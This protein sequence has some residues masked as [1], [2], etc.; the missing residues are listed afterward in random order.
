MT[1]SNPVQR[2]RIRAAAILIENGSILL[3]KQEVSATRHWSL[4]GGSWTG[5]SHWSNA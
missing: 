5:A 3:V 4:P 2:P 1:D